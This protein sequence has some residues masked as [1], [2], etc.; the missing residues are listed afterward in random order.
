MPGGAGARG[1]R[2]NT[3]ALRFKFRTFVNKLAH[4]ACIRPYFWFPSSCLGT[5]G[6]V[7]V[8]Q[9]SSPVRALI[10]RSRL[11]GR[12]APPTLPYPQLKNF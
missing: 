12:G 10:L 2:P 5:R 7:L 3:V 4:F 1:L 11:P 8:A 9:V 6:K